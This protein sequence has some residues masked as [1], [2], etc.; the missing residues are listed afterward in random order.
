MKEAPHQPVYV[1]VLVR[2]NK[3][4]FVFFF[5]RENA[6]EVREQF[7]RYA[8]D[9]DME[10]NWYDAAVLSGRLQRILQG[11]QIAENKPRGTTPPF[12][13]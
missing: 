12:R 11:D 5:T 4:Y 13:A 8:A 9:P 10:F 2:A 3:E 7:G 6:N 1:L